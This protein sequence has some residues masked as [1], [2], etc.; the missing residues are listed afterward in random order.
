[1]NETDARRVT[2]VE[3][4]DAADSPLWTREDGRWATRLTAQ[5]VPAGAKPE[6]WAVERAHHALERLR[7][8]D[9][10]VRNWLARSGWRWSWMFAAVVVGYALGLTAD[11]IGRGRYIDLLAPTL[12]AIVAWNVAIYAVL[13]LNAL[14]GSVDTTG[15]FRRLLASWWE[16]GVGTGPLRQ[17]A[18]RWS[19]RS[20]ALTASRTAAVVHAAAAALGLGM[21][22]GLYLRGLV[23]DFRA[24]W[25]STFLDGAMVNAILGVLLAPASAVSGLALPDAATIEVMRLTPTTPDPSAP[26]GLWIHL[27]AATL[28]LFV[29]A[30]RV[31]LAVSAL[32]RSFAQS[33][34]MS[35]PIQVE[36]LTRF[37][38][39]HPGGAAPLV[40][41]LPY[42]QLPGAQAAL[43]LRELLA[44]E[45]GEDLVVKIADLT[46]IGDEDAAAARAGS[47]AAVLRAALVDLG[48]T[49]E[50]EHHGR[51]LRALSTAQP[52]SPTLLLVDEAAYRLRFGSLPGRLQER[53]EAW[54]NFAQQHSL[55]A[56]IVNLDQPEQPES[57]AALQQALAL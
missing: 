23:F 31:L 36:A 53:R 28:L 8:R 49:P 35:L 50:D 57:Q 45:L 55:R 41:V 52:A 11:L 17:A 16:R 42:A 33:L 21:V 44:S 18:T 34:R 3:A 12:W 15:W 29:V 22:S 5:T 7:P 48:A 14:R 43:G 46:A 38:R 39:W 47:A 20:A 13:A 40:Q 56:A 26:A 2:L 9:P 32:T 6:R 24:A 4:F 30:P 54:Q 19:E 51:L 25:Q 37:A 10:A 1:V 27:F